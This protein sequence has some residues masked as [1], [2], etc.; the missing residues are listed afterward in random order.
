LPVGGQST[1]CKA[2]LGNVLTPH[3]AK[4]VFSG[5]ADPG[6]TITWTP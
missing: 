2:Y 3:V 5:F 4:V 6:V 1:D